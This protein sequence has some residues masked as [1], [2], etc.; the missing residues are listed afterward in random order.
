MNNTN[1]TATNA[2][3]T[4]F[5]DKFTEMH[6]SGP[7]IAEAMN[8]SNDRSSAET[9]AGS[10][11]AAIYDGIEPEA[12]M[13][14]VQEA[15][16]RGVSLPKLISDYLRT[17]RPVYREYQEILRKLIEAN[18]NELEEE[19]EI[20]RDYAKS[21]EAVPEN[22]RLEEIKLW[23]RHWILERLLHCHPDDIIFFIASRHIPHAEGEGE[24]LNTLAIL[25]PQE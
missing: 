24:L 25:R 23:R 6:E 8:A 16:R 21:S 12:I 4:V 19:Y 7:Q 18:K 22:H 3:E 11:N 17:F 13:W 5:P 9:R 15:A 14:G 20:Q 1:Q 2:A 10:G